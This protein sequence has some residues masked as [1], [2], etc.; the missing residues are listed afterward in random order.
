[1]LEYGVSDESHCQEKIF[2]SCFRFLQR[3]TR[4][5]SRVCHSYF[6]KFEIFVI[7]AQNKLFLSFNDFLEIKSAVAS[8]TCLLSEVKILSPIHASKTTVLFI[9]FLQVFSNNSSL[10]EQLSEADIK[11]LFFASISSSNPEHYELTVTLQ[12]IIQVNNCDCCML[13]VILHSEHEAS[14]Y[15]ARICVTALP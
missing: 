1:M 6:V 14:H 13:H 12:T 9:Y 4:K 3:M 11:K 7:Q 2:S 8:M 5:N 10:C 15:F